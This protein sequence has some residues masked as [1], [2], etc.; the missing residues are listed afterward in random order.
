MD[1]FQDI[2][3]AILTLQMPDGSWP[4][5]TWTDPYLSSVF[6]LLT[7][8]KITPVA[9]VEVSV[10][11]KPGSCPNPFNRTSKGVVSIAVLGDEDFDVTLI[12][13]ET[14]N[15]EGVS[16]VNWHTEDVATPFAGELEDKY[17]C[18]T[19]GPDGYMDLV[20]HFDTE[21]LAGCLAGYDKGAVVVL[22][23]EGQLTD[24]RQFLGEDI[25]WIVK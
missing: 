18:N 10:D 5:S 13:P 14:V 19:F 9:I 20:F 25:I 1:W 4:A 21:V 24:G 22:A 23:V 11:I 15:I 2:S 6:N 16:P 7:L 8:E 3:Q 12:D 17:D